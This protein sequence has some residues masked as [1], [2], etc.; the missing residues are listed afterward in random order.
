M[1][2][3]NGNAYSDPFPHLILENFYNEEELE[4]VWEELKYYTKPG[5]LLEPKDFGGVV[6]AIVTDPTDENNKVVSLTKGTDAEIWA[7]TTIASGSIF[8]PLSSTEAGMTLRV[9]SPEA[10]VQVKLKLEESGDNEKVVE[11]DA[12]TTVSSDWETLTF[13]FRNHTEGTPALNS[14]YVFDTLIVYINYGVGGSDETYY[15][16]DIKFIGEIPL[17]VTVSSLAG[18]WKMAPEAGAS[19][20]ARHASAASDTSHSCIQS[21]GGEP[22]SSEWLGRG[23]S[24]SRG[25]KRLPQ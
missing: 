4:L 9:W 16:D 23:Y 3:L 24:I 1:E 10:G 25:A 6:G 14:S 8:Y 21:A 20:R 13:N 2:T 22:A 17:D 11:T 12:V 19:H 5:K 15:L 7:G 18:N